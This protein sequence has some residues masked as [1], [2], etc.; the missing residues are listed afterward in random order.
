MMK[1]PKSEGDETIE[2]KKAHRGCRGGRKNGKKNKP[3]TIK[4]ETQV[5]AACDFFDE[6]TD[7]L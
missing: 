5:R 3:V 2:G 6:D 1:N 7:R 4:N